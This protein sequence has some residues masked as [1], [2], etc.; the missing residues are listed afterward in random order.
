[1]EASILSEYALSI[2]AHYAANRQASNTQ[3]LIFVSLCAVALRNTGRA[4]KDKIYETMREVLKSESGI[5]H[6]QRLIR[7]AKWA[8][9]AVSSLT[10][11]WKT[12]SWDILIFGM[13]VVLV[14]HSES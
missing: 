3:E 14:C 5:P 6:L 7:G 4:E 10:S 11:S 9:R 1:M 12:R 8:N 2:K 13:L